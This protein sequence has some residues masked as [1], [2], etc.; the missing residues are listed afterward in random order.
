MPINIHTSHRLIFWLP[1]SLYVVLVLVCAIVP[2]MQQQAR[3]DAVPSPILNPIV[4][5]GRDVYRSFNC[6]TC[7]TQQVRGD[8]HRAVVVEGRR[9]VPPLAADRRF[10]VE[11]SVAAD[12]DHESPALM[13]TQRTGPDLTGVGDRLPGYL[14]H[15][16]HLYDPRSVSP[17]SV[18]PSYRFM[19]STSP[20]PDGAEGW[21]EIQAIEGMGVDGQRLWAT[22]EAS[23]LVEY[24]LSLRTEGK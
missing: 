1:A 13:G 9:V 3:Q 14:W 7:H 17:D 18:M 23:A 11:A 6:V 19:Y 15:H 10:A 8:E 20:P 4:Q 2:A 5:R 12:Y 21:Q 22:P 16:W 24:L